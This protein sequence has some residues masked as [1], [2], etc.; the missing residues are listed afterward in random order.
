M[1]D[2]TFGRSARAAWDDMTREPDDALG[3]ADLDYTV[4]R[5]GKVKPILPV[6]KDGERLQPWGW[7]PNRYRYRGFKLSRDC[8]GW[9]ADFADYGSGP[10]DTIEAAMLDV[11]GFHDE[12]NDQ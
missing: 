4:S 6:T 3:G 5:T 1:S 12:N 11:D 10:F 9:W 7:T 2:Q 8:D